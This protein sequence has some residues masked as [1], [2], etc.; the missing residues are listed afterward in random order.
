MTWF[1]DRLQHSV[2]MHRVMPWE[3]GAFGQIFGDCDNIFPRVQTPDVPFGVEDGGDGSISAPVPFE[4]RTV[5]IH[6]RAVNFG[7]F[8]TKRY[9]NGYQRAL[10]IKDGRLFCFTPQMLRRLVNIWPRSQE[11]SGSAR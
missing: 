1:E 5:S 2:V 6:V 9:G 4:Q 3:T 8:K 7:S 10:S 11:P